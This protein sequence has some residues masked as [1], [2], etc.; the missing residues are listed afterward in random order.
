MV[1]RSEA[2]Y[3][4]IIL[5]VF[6]SILTVGLLIAL[7]VLE[8]QMRREREAELI[9]RGRQ[10][11][12]AVRR[13]ITKHPGAYPKSV[14][15]LVKERFLRKA[16]PDPMTKDGA[17]NLIL[18]MGPPGAAPPRG[19]GSSRGEPS[20]FRNNL[21]QSQGPAR[22]EAGGSPASPQQVMI[23]P[24]ASLSAVN[25]PR[26][27]GVVSSSPQKSFLIY[28]ENETYDSWLFYYG[29]APGSKPEIVR[30]GNPVK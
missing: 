26:I 3:T 16:F 2:G 30:F 28:E 1:R 4:L 11:V 15:D 7:P 29:S 9:F 19:P 20:P 23:V 22:P 25:N 12:E 8:T 13:Y 24:E 6:I 5:M 14:E 10:Y 18:Q 27:I 21:M 17:W